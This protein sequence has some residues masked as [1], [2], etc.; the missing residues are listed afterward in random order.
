MCGRFRLTRKD[1]E[2]RE[3]FDIPDEY[4][5]K[6]RFN[7]APTDIVPVVRQDPN[8]PKKQVVAAH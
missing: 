5:W 7:I 4:E 3:H 1:R 2:L 6:P 8:K